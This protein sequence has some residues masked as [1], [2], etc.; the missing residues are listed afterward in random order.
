MITIYIPIW[1]IGS[2]KLTDQLEVV[3]HGFAPEIRRGFSLRSQ[4]PRPGGLQSRTRLRPDA[5]SRRLPC[6][7]EPPRRSGCRQRWWEGL[8]PGSPCRLA[9]HGFHDA[10]V[11]G[12]QNHVPDVLVGL[13]EPVPE[14][15][16]YVT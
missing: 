12:R 14:D 5:L 8:G 11:D 16:L 6:R 3:S 1:V 15:S 7:W 10:V 2:K 4:T 13:L 9:E